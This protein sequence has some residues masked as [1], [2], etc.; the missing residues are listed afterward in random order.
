MWYRNNA[1]PDKLE[2]YGGIHME[3]EKI[4]SNLEQKGY[5]VSVFDTGTEV[6]R[7]LKNNI[8]GRT[9]GF[10]GSQTLTE[11][12]LRKELAENNILYVPDFAPEGET[13][14]STAAKAVDTD[15]FFLSANAVSENGEIV[16]IDGTGNR[17]AGSLFGHK[18]VYYIIGQNKFGGS[19]EQ[20]V[21]RARN[22]ASPK[23]A[24]RLHCKT[25]CAM[26]VVKG[27]EQRFRETHNVAGDIDQLEWQRFIEELTDAELNTHCYDCKS[28]QRICGSLLIH[29]TKPDSME[30]EIIIIKENMGF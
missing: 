20:A 14:L 1:Q 24:L 15:L 11:L 16:N 25:P 18:K 9:I 17:L 8:T 23:N 22:V 3:L 19:L 27:L 2:F 29:L 21:N 5:I 7:Y 30:A 10:G 26:A 28:P 12:N 13:F 4:I 6:I